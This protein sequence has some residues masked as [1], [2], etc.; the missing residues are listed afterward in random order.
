MTE[1]SCQL[2]EMQK[3]E[4]CREVSLTYTILLRSFF[5]AY[6]E[7][8]L[9]VAKDF[10]KTFSDTL[11]EKNRALKDKSLKEIIMPFICLTEA[12]GGGPIELLEESEEKIVY[13]VHK[14]HSAFDCSAIDETLCRTLNIISENYAKR[15]GLRYTFLRKGILK[16]L[17]SLAR[18]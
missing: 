18:N 13:R 12:L 11:Y 6:G 15:M 4:I 10:G 9:K 8:S 17:K 7:D 3:L 2:S 14:C 16:I 1:I 5:N